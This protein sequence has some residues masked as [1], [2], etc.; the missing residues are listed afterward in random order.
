M[1]GIA[2]LV[3]RDRDAAVRDQQALLDAL[4]HRGPDDRG[5][6]R[7]SPGAAASGG[8]GAVGDGP[9]RVG[10]VHARLAIIDLSEGGWQPQ[11]TADGSF[12]VVMNG[13][14]YN[15][16]E[17]RAELQA[18]GIAF[19]T[20]SDTEVLL[21]AWQQWGAKCLSRLVGMFAFA[22]LDT[23][24]NEVTLVRDPFG[25]KPL[26]YAQ[27]D[28][29][30]AF[31]SEVPGLLSLPNVPATADPQRLYDYLRWGQVDHDDRTMFAAIKSVPA[32]HLVRVDV[33]RAQVRPA[34]RYWSLPEETIDVGLDE[35]AEQ[36]RELFMDSIRL[37]L[38]SDV[39]VGAALSGGID[40][41]AIVMAAREVGGPNLDLECFSFIADDARYDEERWVDLIAQSAPVEVHKVRADGANLVDDLDDLVR[42]QGEPFVS[43]SIYAQRLVF[44]EARRRGVTVLLDGQGADEL[45]AG[46]RSHLAGQFTSLVKD[47]RLVAAA[48]LAGS[49]GRRPDVHLDRRTVARAAAGVLPGPGRTAALRLAGRQPFPAWLDRSW[50]ETRGVASGDVATGRANGGLSDTL[51]TA[52]T[53]TSLPSLLR[54]EDRNSMAY[55]L[56]SRVPFLTPPLVEYV[57]RL[58]RSLLMS[59]DGLSKLVFRKAMRG[60][61]PEAILERRDKIGFN[62]PELAWFE[63]ARSW[64]DAT[65]TSPAA[66]RVA[67]LD[68]EACQRDWGRLRDGRSRFDWRVW[69]W[70]NVIRWAELFEVEFE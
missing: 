35:A 24:R 41:S 66:T 65:F 31:S 36:L 6:L 21:A 45:F 49:V 20:E 7:W 54:Y 63:Q 12:H 13:E 29:G 1:C 14:I 4:D 33:E 43:T 70:L 10:F 42:S 32:A 61:V 50:F 16:V 48:K 44:R 53:Q 5:W 47:R 64:V 18:A 3:V 26:F 23:A 19:T 56:E 30:L 51:Q 28:G 39:P 8:H 37:H 17:L 15:Y 11:H 62:T 40:S 60:I 69:R 22:V 68:R 67:A 58:P 34:E 38:R 59:N 46:Y 9:G 27:W 52:F 2:G 55:S 25:I 57:F